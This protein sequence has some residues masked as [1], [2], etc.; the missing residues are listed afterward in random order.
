LP[1]FCPSSSLSYI[2]Y[3]PHVGF[4]LVL[5]L[6]GGDNHGQA[7]GLLEGWVTDRDAVDRA[8]P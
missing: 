4:G 2:V 1:L 6:Y 8:R 7:A 3:L 5:L